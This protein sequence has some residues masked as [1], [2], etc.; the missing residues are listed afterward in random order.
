MDLSILD[1]GLTITARFP[2][3]L[4]GFVPRVHEIGR[5]IGYVVGNVVVPDET[6]DH[7]I[8][9][10]GPFSILGEGALTIHFCSIFLGREKSFRGF[11]SLVFLATVLVVAGKVMWLL[12]VLHA[13]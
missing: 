2:G 9:Q 6:A 7:K 12:I 8:T 1:G 11:S 4:L 13:R 10:D 3:L 5:C